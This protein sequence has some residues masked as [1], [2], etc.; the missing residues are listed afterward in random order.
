MVILSINM[1]GLQYITK[2]RGILGNLMQTIQGKMISI[3]FVYGW[4]C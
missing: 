3:Y 4:L 1:S 2:K